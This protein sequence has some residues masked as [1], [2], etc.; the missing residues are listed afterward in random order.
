MRRL[1][2]LVALLTAALSAQARFAQS[3]L[4]EVVG[5][6]EAILDVRISSVRTLEWGSSEGVAACGHIYEAR[7]NETLKGLRAKSVT[8]ASPESFLVGGRYVLFFNSYTGD[9]PTDVFYRRPPEEEARR[10]T[11]LRSLP[12]LKAS[13]L[14]WGKFL[15]NEFVE[16]SYW[17]VPPEEANPAEVSI[18]AVRSRGTL[19]DFPGPMENRPPEV[20]ALFYEHWLE[21]TVVHWPL[22]KRAIEGVV[23]RGEDADRPVPTDP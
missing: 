20:E 4:D 6:T 2:L 8:F 9:F 11:C 3:P 16:L 10:Q 23:V 17:L 13:W 1:V 18:E 21:S 12:K 5:R 14:H 7:V 19:V 22:L 15:P